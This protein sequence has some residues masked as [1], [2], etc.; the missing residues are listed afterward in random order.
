MHT[1]RWI[2][3][4]VWLIA[5]LS[6]SRW[7]LNLLDFNLTCVLFLRMRRHPFHS[8]SHQD[9]CLSSDWSAAIRISSTVPCQVVGRNFSHTTLNR[10][11]HPI[12]SVS[13]LTLDL[14]LVDRL[15][16]RWYIVHLVWFMKAELTTTAPLWSPSFSERVQPIIKSNL[17]QMWGSY[18]RCRRTRF[19]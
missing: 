18:T 11:C 6:T 1:L 9:P 19:R 16:V 12:P 4:T 15:L 3:N 5:P 13:D 14:A 8:V 7:H 2:K 10:R 17:I